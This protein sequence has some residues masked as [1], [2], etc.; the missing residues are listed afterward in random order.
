MKWFVR[1]LGSVGL[2]LIIAIGGLYLFAPWEDVRERAVAAIE[3]ATGWRADILGRSSIVLF[4]RFGVTIDG[5][6]LVSPAA[7]Q[8]GLRIEAD[9]MSAQLNPIG[10]LFGAIN[11]TALT[12][13][14]PVF[15]VVTS[16]TDQ[17]V[18]A[19][20][21]QLLEPN[22]AQSG[23]GA[24]D[25]TDSDIQEIARR[26]ETLSISRFEITD[27]SLVLD[28][29]KRE[30]AVLVPV[31]SNIDALLSMPRGGPVDLSI[32]FRVNDV[33]G[34]LEA[35][36]ASPR[37]LMAGGSTAGR[38][39]GAYANVSL[40][41]TGEYDAASDAG[42][43][44]L[45]V[46]SPSLLK[47]LAV[48]PGA[49]SETSFLVAADYGVDLSG[50]VIFASRRV[51]LEN[52]GGTVADIPLSGMIEIATYGDRTQLLGR[53]AAT[54][55][56][57][58]P[59]LATV[60][61]ELQASGTLSFDLGFDGDGATATEAFANL[62]WSGSMRIQ[63]GTAT[64]PNGIRAERIDL[65]VVGEAQD[66]AVDVRGSLALREEPLDIVAHLTPP[67]ALAGFRLPVDI[68][69]R[70]DVGVLAFEGD[71]APGDM[72]N[73]VFR[74]ETD[75]LSRLSALVGWR[76]NAQIPRTARLSG[77]IE[78]ADALWRVRDV[79]FAIDGSDGRFDGVLTLGERPRLTGEVRLETLAWP[80]PDI[81]R[82]APSAASARETRSIGWST[83]PVDLS[84]LT[85]FDADLSLSAR[86]MRFGSF[87]AGPGEAR[88]T[89]VSGQLDVELT[90][91][92]VYGGWASGRMSVDAA[93]PVPLVAVNGAV[94]AVSI[95]PLLEAAAGFYRVEGTL[96]AV[97][98]LTST[99]AS[100]AD[101][102]ARLD[103]TA[104]VSLT[105]GSISGVNVGAL[106]RIVASAV[107][108]GWNVSR[109]YRT[110]FARL[111]ASFRVVDGR[112]ESDDLVLVGPFVRSSG[113]GTTDLGARRL[114]WRVEPRIV[115]SLDGIPVPPR[116]GES[117]AGEGF[118]VPLI[119]RGPWD[120]PLIYPDIAGILEDPDA[121]YH[122][123]RALG[124]GF[125]TSDE[126]TR[127][128]LGDMASDA[129]R[130]A[131]GGTLQV[132]ID[133]V[134][135]GEADEREVLQTIEEGFNL[136]SGFL[137]RFGLG[138]D[139]RALD[140]TPQAVE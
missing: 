85:S 105:D 103:G 115:P 125:L 84:A 109:D 28:G 128:A 29:S 102:L 3:S 112:A 8:G 5:L 49:I 98:D 95:R 15:T 37:A 50:D 74:L 137:S 62:G 138:S 24:S 59:L 40:S 53:L 76:S 80:M 51:R 47:A 79:A 140:P 4:P 107:S 6:Q 12:L 45:D 89:L 61:P 100:A 122:Q 39:E 108:E 33:P 132:D 86:E 124:K 16:G 26:F 44:V 134:L 64:L 2:L 83:D 90:S 139:A 41:F 70:G 136:P 87:V 82:D 68:E 52:M 10:L 63:D 22:T 131:T 77:A 133:R 104:A 120:A 58:A 72:P 35:Q 54:R 36:I 96:G 97:F 71:L 48:F 118:G 30:S 123:L 135:S 7:E 69:I 56:S 99:G 126:A 110:D 21:R 55:A 27:G 34:R 113:S 106:M 42:A 121:A 91:L 60:E 78:Q 20:A 57:L 13:T 46:S 17:G 101:L 119:V 32:S 14:K 9:A 38:L 73:G 88:M 93:A 18:D 66:A 111:S 81:Q 67:S 129:V 130:E 23:G 31:A 11:I 114:D 116:K 127:A 65:N 92:T 117:A 43:G 25:H 94:D 1:F 19:D 75:D